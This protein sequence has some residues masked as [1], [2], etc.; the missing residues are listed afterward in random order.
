MSLLNR[1]SSALF[2]WYLTQAV[3]AAA[4]AEVRRVRKVDWHLVI[5]ILADLP[6]NTAAYIGDFDC[7][8]RAHLKKGGVEYLDPDKY[9]IWTHGIPG[10]PRSRASLFMQEK[11]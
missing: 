5:E 11:R 1:A 6:D 3:Y 2:S 7:S 8:L 9:L 10:Q 4:M